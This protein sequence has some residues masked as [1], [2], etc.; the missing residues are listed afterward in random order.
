MTGDDAVVCELCIAVATGLTK[1]VIKQICCC[2]AHALVHFLKVL[3]H[4]ITLLS[5]FLC[6]SAIRQAGDYTVQWL[7]LVCA[8]VH[9]VSNDHE[10]TYQ[11]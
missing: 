2:V 6:M 11:A 3:L 1:V 8:C 5:P 4:F 7:A 10:C 9:R